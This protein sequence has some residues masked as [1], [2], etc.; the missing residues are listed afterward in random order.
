MLW[1]AAP[2]AEAAQ[3]R[4]HHRRHARALRDRDL[5]AALDSLHQHFDYNAGKETA[6][7]WRSRQQGAPRACTVV[8]A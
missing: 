3:R 7:G 2:D 4:S 8:S 5:L 1:Q 6:C